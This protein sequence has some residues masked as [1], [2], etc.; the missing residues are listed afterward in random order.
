M[1][2][3]Q[4]SPFSSPGFHWKLITIWHGV[5]FVY[6]FSPCH[7][8]SNC[9]C[10]ITVSREGEEDVSPSPSPLVPISPSCTSVLCGALVLFWQETCTIAYHYCCVLDF[11]GA[12]LLCKSLQEM[13]SL[14]SEII[15]K[16]TDFLSS[17]V[18]WETQW[19][20]QY[21][22][23]LPG[24]E[25]CALETIWQYLPK[26]YFKVLQC[27]SCSCP[28]VVSLPGKGSLWGEHRCSWE[29]PWLSQRVSLRCR[30]SFRLVKITL[31]VT[32]LISQ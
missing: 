6:S 32:A 4:V 16:V 28:E 12:S 3:A 9:L 17:I 7:R 8:N 13:R 14:V 1:T 22:Q 19:E 20:H 27:T 24:S 18:V 25:S 10:K 15:H 29:Y 23:L 31:L 5:T 11:L 26:K 21:P 2:H 30:Y